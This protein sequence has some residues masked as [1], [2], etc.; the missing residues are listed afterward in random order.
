M[1]NFNHDWEKRPASQY[2][3]ATLGCC[4]E[5]S[6]QCQW[7][8]ACNW[9]GSV[10]CQWDAACIWYGSVQCQWAAACI[11]YGSVQCQW[12]AAC[13]WYGSVHNFLIFCPLLYDW[14][15]SRDEAQNSLV[16]RVTTKATTKT[17]HSV[18]YSRARIVS[19]SPNMT[20]YFPATASTAEFVSCVGEA[21]DSTA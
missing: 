6:V 10:Q 11:W 16:Q 18:T 17:L 20:V 12:A 9:Y 15:I 13:I 4:Y 1:Q 21:V 14:Q 5:C 7:D 19:F 3:W 8:A 2:L